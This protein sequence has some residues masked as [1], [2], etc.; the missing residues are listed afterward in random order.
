M[1]NTLP[2]TQGQALMTVCAPLPL[3]HELLEGNSVTKQ[4]AYMFAEEMREFLMLLEKR[5]TVSG[6]PG[7][8][9]GRE[10]RG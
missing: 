4:G 5:I 7:F 2:N 3:G 1:C 8:P 9:A 6:V 10:V